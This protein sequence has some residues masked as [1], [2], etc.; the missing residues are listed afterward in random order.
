MKKLLKLLFVLS[1]TTTLPLSVIACGQETLDNILNIIYKGETNY[2][3]DNL[4]SEKEIEPFKEK[5]YLSDNETSQLAKNIFKT[6]LNNAK[7]ETEIIWANENLET[8]QKV[9]DFKITNGTK[10]ENE[11][12]LSW[13]VHKPTGLIEI[14]ISYLVGTINSDQKFNAKQKIDMVFKIK[15]CHSYSD[16]IIEEW[17]DNFNKQIK[18]QKWDSTN[19]LVINLSENDI[20]LPKSGG[21]WSDLSIK[22]KQATNN[23][24]HQEIAS[25]GSISW[26]IGNSKDKTITKDLQLEIY[27]SVNK[28]NKEKDTNSFIIQFK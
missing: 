11:E 24:I 5:Y 15:C 10:V 2:S 8:N 17:V 1:G 4:L 14:K 6:A 13:E 9:Y 18:E 3:I 22:I 20:E 16:Q 25:N 28:T 19:P 27:L 26:G 7:N 12:G 23:I 21:N